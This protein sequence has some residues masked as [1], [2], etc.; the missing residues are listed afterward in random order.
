[1]R[2]GCGRER[3]GAVFVP[4]AAVH[5]LHADTASGA[6]YTA[7]EQL[8]LSGVDLDG[9]VF[10]STFRLRGPGPIRVQSAACPCLRHPFIGSCAQMARLFL[11]ASL[12]LVLSGCDET[13]IQTE[14]EPAEPAL[15]LELVRSVNTTL[16]SSVDRARL[17][18][19]NDAV[20]R[21]VDVALPPEGAARTVGVEVPDGIYAVA[22]V[23][24][25]DRWNEAYAFA[26]TTGVEVDG[27][28]LARLSLD[29]A[30]VA[31]G[32]D[33]L[34]AE[35]IQVKPEM[36]DLMLEAFFTTPNLHP[37][38]PDATLHYH[39]GTFTAPDSAAHH[40]PMNPEL[41]RYYVATLP[42]LS[43]PA[44]DDSVHFRVETPLNSAWGDSL[45]AI[46][47]SVAEGEEAYSASLG[48]GIVVT[49]IERS[50]AW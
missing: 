6:R 18:V 19:W 17:R 38:L 45:R 13:V 4:V 32:P 9:K 43:D 36:G 1:M 23:V 27:N 47:P 3:P 16:P 39:P 46:A 42:G 29:I 41:N 44:F 12:F 7:P 22:L 35:E 33:Y 34:I 8:R 10:R 50:T 11:F 48:G 2:A 26:D 25:S 24:Y 21:S 30:S 40:T 15:G 20:E 28:E 37:Q 14:L 5:W 31:A 49:F